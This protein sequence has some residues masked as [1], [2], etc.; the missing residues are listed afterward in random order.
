MDCTRGGI[1]PRKVCAP[2][3]RE[4]QQGCLQGSLGVPRGAGSSSCWPPSVRFLGCSW[5]LGAGAGLGLSAAPGA[6]SPVPSG[7][8]ASWLLQGPQ[9]C[10]AG[11]WASPQGTVGAGG[12][13]PA[14]FLA[15]LSSGA[16]RV[17]GARLGEPELGWQE[18]R[19]RAGKVSMAPAQACAR[20]RPGG[21]VGSGH[22]HRQ[23]DGSPQAG[24]CTSVAAAS[25]AAER[26]VGAGEEGLPGAGGEAPHTIPAGKAR[27]EHAQLG[28][29]DPPVHCKVHGRQMELR[30]V[31]HILGRP[32]DNVGGSLNELG[33]GEKEAPWGERSCHFSSL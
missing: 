17:P 27:G 14:G 31:S 29:R 1:C 6:R 10:A 30:G 7:A 8:G 19:L 26:E 15:P 23:Q 9:G 18:G 28:G 4:K 16:L 3:E 13:G 20:F 12:A 5:V 33:G 11:A 24:G 22:T 32:A 25:R 2:Q 21:R